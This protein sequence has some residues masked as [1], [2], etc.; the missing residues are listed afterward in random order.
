MNVIVHKPTDDESEINMQK[1]VATLHANIIREYL[2]KL[3]CSR[4][5]KIEILNK[6]EKEL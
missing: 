4:S 2:N 5:Q 1:L 6:I 3:Q